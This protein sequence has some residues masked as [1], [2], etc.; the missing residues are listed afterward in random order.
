MKNKHLITGALL[1]LSW[2]TYA[3]KVGAN[4][5]HVNEVLSNT[6]LLVGAAILIAAI[7]AL[8]RVHS[9]ISESIKIQLL[10]EHGVDI[11]EKV[12]LSVTKE[13]WW[14]R[15]YKK[16]TN[17]V[18][19]EKEDDIML[20]HNYDGIKELDNSLPPWWVAMFYISIAFGAAY[21]YFNHFSDYAQSSEEEYIAEMELAEEEIK[22]HIAMQANVVDETNAEMLQDADAIAIGGA[23][24]N[25]NCVACHGSL[26]EGGVGPNLT[27]D[28][29]LHGGDIKDVFKTIKYGVPEKGMIAWQAQLPPAEIHKISSYIMTLVGTSPPN[30]KEPQGEVYQIEQVQNLEEEV[31]DKSLGMK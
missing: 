11:L 14:K 7:V 10:Q 8:M 15:Q 22:A 1:L 17:V 12:D 30:G 5:E 3:Q 20:D 29:W 16:W 23:L 25:A 28:Y 6:V 19:V 21:I 4:P 27:D 18:P 26:G 9:M 13:S 2:S 24:Y 31:E